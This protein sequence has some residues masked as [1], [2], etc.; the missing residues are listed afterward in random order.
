MAESPSKG[1]TSL[2]YHYDLRR[3][4]CPQRR[5]SLLLSKSLW[6]QERS[7]FGLRRHRLECRYGLLGADAPPHIRSRVELGRKA[8]AFGLCLV[9]FGYPHDFALYVR[10]AVVWNMIDLVVNA[11]RFESE[12][13]A[14]EEDVG[15][16]GRCEI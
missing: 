8:F 2:I 16:A 14:S 13:S 11:M 3:C 1:I 10:E 6:P 7:L 12:S 15:L 9:D 4:H 5:R